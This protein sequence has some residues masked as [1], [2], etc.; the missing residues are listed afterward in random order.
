MESIIQHLTEVSQK[1]AFMPPE[2]FVPDDERFYMW[3]IPFFHTFTEEVKPQDVIN[4]LTNDG[5]G[6]GN[7]RMFLYFWW[8][9][10]ENAKK[11]FSDDDKKDISTYMTNTKPKY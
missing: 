4:R 9:H 10:R 1:S 7:I 3:H 5:F 2:G 8:V 11:P 6:E